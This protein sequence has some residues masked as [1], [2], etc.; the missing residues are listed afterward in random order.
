V[1]VNLSRT[2]LR[3]AIQHVLVEMSDASEAFE[4]S[5]AKAVQLSCNGVIKATKMGAT[6]LSDVRIEAPGVVT[7]LEA[8]MGHKDNL[9]NPRI[10]F[11]DGAWRTTYATPVAIKA[12]ALANSSREAAQFL[13][14]L[15]DFVGTIDIAVPTT[16]GG[17]RNPDAVPLETMRQ[18]V[19]QRGSRYFTKEEDINIGDLVTQHYLVGKDEPAHYLQAGND[20]YLIGTEDPL[21]LQDVMPKGEKI[22]VLSGRGDFKLR[23]STRS[24]F[25]E[26]QAEIKVK[27]FTPPS[28]PAS[29]FGGKKINPFELLCGE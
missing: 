7:Y 25:Y 6:G 14:D 27:E 18:F 22:P 26:V 29:V 13:D 3:E 15:R 20:L 16:K 4:T 17:L 9:A 8:K 10:F 11:L 24:E 2:M 21:G 19:D 28:S 12:A 23:V 1:I 5:V